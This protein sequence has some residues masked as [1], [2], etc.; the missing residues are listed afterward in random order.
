VTVVV[1]GGAGFIGR[2]LIPL[3][4]ARGEHVTCMDINPGAAAFEPL[5]EAVRVVR[6]DVT[7]FDD[8]MA[9]VAEAK[10]SRLINLSYHIGSDLPPHVATKL[11]VVGMDNCFEAARLCGVPHTI[12]A[13]SLAVS[14]QQRHFGER[15]TT[16]EDRCF[17]D[18]QYAMN[19]IFNEFQ[20]RDYA[21]KFGMT[22][23][24]IRPA[25]VTGPDKLRGSVDHVNC[26]TQPA[27]GRP[28][29]FPFGDAMRIPIH[30][31]DIAEVFARVAAVEKPRHAIYNSGGTTISLGE[32]AEMVRSFLP[33]ARITFEQESGGRERSGNFLIDNR[34]LVEEFGVQYAPFRQR[35]LQI[36]ND[37]RS[38]EGMPPLRGD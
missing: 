11:N 36:I 12:Y 33:D 34:R 13:S 28:V 37:I 20:A 1:I 35:V 10:P 18:N 16:E 14:G 8:V 38:D 31:D 30:V 5:G 2:R 19:K 4:V 3:L 26:I 24:G 32:L 27:R 22:I 9:V 21:E 25:N 6:G 29:T 23:T 17:G 7:Q 15:A